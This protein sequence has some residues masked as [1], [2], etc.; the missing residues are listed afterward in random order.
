MIVKGSVEDFIYIL[1]GIIWIAF[2]I[3]KGFKGSQKK[4]AESLTTEDHYE[5]EP[6]DVSETKVRKSV[7]DSFLEEI[8]KQDEPVPHSPVEV[9]KES[10]STARYEDHVSSVTSSY[11]DF[12]EE[13]NY[14]GQ[15]DVY[16]EERTATKPTKQEK[17]ITYLP[18]RRR[19]RI[20]LKKAVIYSEILNRRYF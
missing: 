14:P 19:P 3:Y 5:E 13:S 6:G 15:T 18:R 10:E 20:D 8:I 4:K 7:F 2:S 1:I 16:N 9:N 17:L 12:H 11:D